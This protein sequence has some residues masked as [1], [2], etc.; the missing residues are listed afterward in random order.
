MPKDYIMPG[1]IC[2]CHHGDI[3]IVLRKS[4]IT[5]RYY[6]ITFDGKRWESHHPIFVAKSVNEY[7]QMENDQK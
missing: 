2:R 5:H 1:D 7:W 6:G 4:D 3:G